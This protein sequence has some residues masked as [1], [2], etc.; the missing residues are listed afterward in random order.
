MI[1]IVIHDLQGDI[2]IDSKTKKEL[3]KSSASN[4]LSQGVILAFSLLFLAYFARAF[5]KEQM[6]A[7]ALVSVLAGWNELI[8]TFGM[9]TLLERNAAILAAKGEHERL[10]QL[11]SGAMVYRI[12]GVFLVSLIWF[13]L[14][15]WIA[16]HTFKTAEYAML[17]RY[18]ALISFAASCRSIV[19]DTQGALQHFAAKS[20]ITTVSSIAQQVLSLL[21]Y[22]SFGVYGFFSGY[23]L[24]TLLGIT[25]SFIDIRKYLCRQLIPFN[26]V[27]R[28][29]RAYFGIGTL[30]LAL[31]R[32]DRPLIGVFL[33][34]EA[35]AAYHIAKRLYEN[36]CQAIN[37]LVVPIGIKFGEVDVAG[38]NM[39]SR[40][41]QKTFII[42]AQLFIPM[43]FFVML[44]S[45]PFLY[46]YGGEK[47]I[48]SYP[49]AMAFGFTLLSYSMWTFFRVAGLRLL[50]ARFLAYQVIFSY[51][52]TAVFMPFFCR[53]SAVL[54]SLLPSA[55]VI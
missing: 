25:L 18:I 12:A 17:I 47:Y 36:L 51:S 7:Y 10:K 39:L 49:V 11:V 55:W 24:A 33:G 22:F 44:T 13:A 50:R 31:E 16:E 26:D 35:L 14:S 48:S 15:P 32:I 45:R 34:A 3:A 2:A 38:E 20:A 53:C 5:S 46:L 27:F 6:A 9:G 42:I 21:G 41:Y 8:G 43:S 37:A 28:Q 4:L 52:V 29:S 30:E 54:A 23:L 19:M 1:K 40:Y